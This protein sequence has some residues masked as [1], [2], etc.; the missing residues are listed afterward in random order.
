MNIFILDRNP[1]RAAIEFAIKE[2]LE[3]VEEYKGELDD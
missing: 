2:N 3:V 1:E